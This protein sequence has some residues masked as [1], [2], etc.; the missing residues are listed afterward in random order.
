ME[1]LNLES[2]GLEDV[3]TLQV[4]PITGTPCDVPEP[5]MVISILFFV[6]YNRA[7]FI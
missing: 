4:Q 6:S 1:D 3:Q 7:N 5:V 2:F